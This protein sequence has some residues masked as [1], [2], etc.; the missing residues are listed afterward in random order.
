MILIV[1]IG[2]VHFSLYQAKKHKQDK[3]WAFLVGFCSCAMMEEAFR[4]VVYICLGILLKDFLHIL[5]TL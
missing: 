5:T 2:C 4:V 3:Q 1:L